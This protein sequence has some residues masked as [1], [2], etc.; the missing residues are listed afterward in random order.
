VRR[1]GADEGETVALSPD[2]RARLR[3]QVAADRNLPETERRRLL[4]ELARP[5]V[6]ARTVARI[7]ARAGG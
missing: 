6:P 7:E 4:A 1:I 2:R 3:A 5:K